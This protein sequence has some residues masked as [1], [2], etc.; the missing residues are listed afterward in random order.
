M[1]AKT[2]FDMGIPLLASSQLDIYF[3]L[4]AA[5]YIFFLAGLLCIAG[6]Q[7][8]VL[9]I[10]RRVGV[11]PG[12][13]TNQEPVRKSFDMP[14]LTQILLVGFLALSLVF[15]IVGLF[16]PS[17]RFTLQGAAATVLSLASPAAPLSRDYSLAGVIGQL[18]MGVPPGWATIGLWIVTVILGALVLGF[19]LVLPLLLVLGIL[20]FPSS[21]KVFFHS[22]LLCRTL[23][24]AE[25]FAIVLAGCFLD[26]QKLGDYL[27]APQ[28]GVLTSLLKQFPALFGTTQGLSIAVSPLTGFWFL[29]V[30]S[31]FLLLPLSVIGISLWMYDATAEQPNLVYRTAL[32]L[33][34]LRQ[35]PG[36]TKTVGRGDMYE[37]FAS[38]N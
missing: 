2:A 4:S 29:F 25:L 23:V 28:L 31:L 26:L 13:A 37:L 32:K 33:G 22:M 6:S 35:T 1:L 5:F 30:G 16:T 34:L 14:A 15:V 17:V 8:M 36:A 7:L 10:K 12:S 38:D 21:S 27:L 18:P 24:A 11:I 9:F 19:V 3:Y 20:V